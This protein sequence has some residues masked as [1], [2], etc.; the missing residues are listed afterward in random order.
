MSGACRVS[1]SVEFDLWNQGYT[2]VAGIDE[3]GRGALAGPVV[4]AAVVLPPAVTLRHVDDSKRLTHVE[5]E[6]LFEEI[7]RVAVGIGVGYV[8]AGTI[9]RVNIRRG[10]LLAM[11]AAILHLPCKPD[12]LLIDGRDRAPVTHPQRWFVRGDQTVGSIAA[13]S[14]VAKVSRDRFMA[15]LDRRFPEY[16]LAQHKGYGTAAHLRAI[17]QFGPS[18]IHRVTFRGV[19]PSVGLHG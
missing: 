19:M 10:T 12:F 18:T 2:H 7:L 1:W 3:A 9:D 16:G 15:G 4:A 8:A 13:A 14:I 5:R 17:R 6:A 11:Q